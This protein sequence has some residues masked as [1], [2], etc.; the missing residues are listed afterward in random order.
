MEGAQQE[1][2]AIALLRMVNEKREEIKTLTSEIMELES[3]VKNVVKIKQNIQ[4][5]INAVASFSSE[6]SNDLVNVKLGADLVL[7]E[8]HFS[9]NTAEDDGDDH[10]INSRWH[11][12]VHELDRFCISAN[13]W[14]PIKSDFAKRSKIIIN[15]PKTLNIASIVNY[16]KG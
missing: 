10:I 8:I 11:G 15:F 13:S 12:I 4:K 2:L 1:R 16:L 9:T 3:T 14:N 5:I 7:T 6:N